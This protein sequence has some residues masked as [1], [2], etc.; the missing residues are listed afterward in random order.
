MDFNTK[1]IGLVLSGGGS[2]GIAQAGALKFLEEL[3]IK[4]AEPGIMYTLEGKGNRFKAVL[5]N[6]AE[7]SII[8][9]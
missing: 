9:Q 8:K 2:K 3:N 5:K 4:H 1:S 7:W 6:N